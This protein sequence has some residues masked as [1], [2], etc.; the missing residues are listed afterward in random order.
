MSVLE[1]GKISGR[2]FMAVLTMV[3]LVPVTLV[4]SMVTSASNP[5]DAWIASIISGVVAIPF[6]MLIA[7]LSLK[8]P[9]K[10]IIARLS[11]DPSSGSSLAWSSFGF[12]YK[13]L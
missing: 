7:R 11:S 4:F 9:E 5:Q 1:G 8:F 13:P 12:P 2:Q 6:A 10:T 3:R